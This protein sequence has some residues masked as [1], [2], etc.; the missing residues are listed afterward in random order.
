MERASYRLGLLKKDAKRKFMKLSENEDAAKRCEKLITELTTEDFESLKQFAQRRLNRFSLS[1]MEAGE[2][3][4]RVFLSVLRGLNPNL[5]GRR[6]RP[7]DVTSK[8]AF[9]NYLRGG[10]SSVVDSLFRANKREDKF[11]CQDSN[12]DITVPDA[13]SPAMLA[14]WSD[15]EMVMFA[16]LRRRAPRRLLKTIN[17]W[18]KVF[19]QADRI[20]ATA[21]RKYTAELRTIAAKVVKEL[22]EPD[23]LAPASKHRQT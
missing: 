19:F 14:G 11:R 10:I 5:S 16:R 1:H 18:Q 17:E 23:R 3:C 6:P 7:M 4:Q 13:S 22:G 8:T 20:P 2:V 21:S 9:L 12:V 15:F